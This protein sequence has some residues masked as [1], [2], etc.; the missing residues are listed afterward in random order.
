MPSLSLSVIKWK[1]KSDSRSEKRAGLDCQDV[2]VRS[3]ASTLSELESP[4][5]ALLGGRRLTLP[6]CGIGHFKQEV[7]F[8][9]ITDGEHLT[10]LT[11]MAGTP[12]CICSSVHCVHAS[13]HVPGCHWS[14]RL[15]APPQSH[16]ITGVV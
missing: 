16:N 8:V 4:L 7:A 2:C 3:A 5:N 11:L 10:T 12:L 13:D 6:F 1:R 9:Q 15:I 14:V